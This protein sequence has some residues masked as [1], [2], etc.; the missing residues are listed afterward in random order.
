M[1]EAIWDGQTGHQLAWVKDQQD[2]VRL[3]DEKLVGTYRNG[4]VYDLRGTLVCHLG[5]L[6]E[7]TSSIPL[8]EAFKAL[9]SG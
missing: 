2:V 7:N 4:T 5:L 3:S 1:I 6:G 9:L 8:T